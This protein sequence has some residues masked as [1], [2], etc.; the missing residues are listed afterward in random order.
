MANTPK[1]EVFVTPI[2]AAVFP[3]LITPDTRHVSEGIFKTDVSVPKDI[4]D[5]FIERLEGTLNRF[6]K[7]E[8]STTQQAT[9]AHRPVYTMELTYPI[10][11]EGAT[12]E[13]KA[14]IKLAFVPEETGNVLFR[15]KMNAK[16]TS[17]KGEV[18]EQI[19]VVVMADTGE[20]ITENVWGGSIVRVKGQII[21]YVNAAGQYAGISLR[22]KAVQV[23]ELVS[24]GGNTAFW[25]D[26]DVAES[27]AN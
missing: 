26:F 15:T 2:G 6:F 11:D 4:G 9:L 1:F 23:I 21:P 18:V 17:R 3:Y 20:R 27:T 10:F 22:M 12:D 7:D 13:E 19:P 14:A 8:L 16:F 5:D 24:G 25:S